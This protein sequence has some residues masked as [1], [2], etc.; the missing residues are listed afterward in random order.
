MLAQSNLLTGH[1]N[2]R[3]KTGGVLCALNYSIAGQC[4]MAGCD[5]WGVSWEDDGVTVFE[6]SP[7]SDCGYFVEASSYFDR[8]CNCVFVCVDCSELEFV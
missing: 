2:F 1:R 7:G 3:A 8:Y 6:G 4:A 5:A